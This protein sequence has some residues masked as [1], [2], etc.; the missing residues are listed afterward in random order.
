[1][2]ESQRVSVYGGHIQWCPGTD[3]HRLSGTDSKYLLPS[4]YS[5]THAS[6][7]KMPTVGVF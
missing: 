2:G 5:V 6:S 1:M 3:K 4:L 7:L